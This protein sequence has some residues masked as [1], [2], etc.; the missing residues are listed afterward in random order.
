MRSEFKNGLPTSQ[1]GLSALILITGFDADQTHPSR[2]I[3]SEMSR[4]IGGRIELQSTHSSE[5]RGRSVEYESASRNLSYGGH[6]KRKSLVVVF[7]VIAFFS[8]PSLVR[9]QSESSTKEQNRKAVLS[10]YVDAKEAYEMWKT[11]PEKVN[12]VDSRS[13]AEYVFVG[14]APMAVNIPSEFWVGKWSAEKKK[15][16][17]A[18]NPDFEEEIKARYQR[19]DIILIM[20]R[21]GGRSAKAAVDRLAKMGFT[22]VYSIVDGMEG[23]IVEDEQSYYRGK[24]MRN[25]WKNSGAPW[26]YKLDPKLVYNPSK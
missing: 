3:S 18:P 21:S 13:V 7:A 24:R 26:T 15:Y 11:A 1:S 6:M 4:R 17:L 23:D 12:I 5:S 2:L 19:D 8:G 9:A 22:N 10:K 16:P 14:H 25:G 20:C